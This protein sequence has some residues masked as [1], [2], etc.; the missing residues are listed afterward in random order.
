M[1]DFPAR[2]TA[3][4]GSHELHS[5]AEENVEIH[6]QAT[7]N[8]LTVWVQPARGH[9]GNCSMPGFWA[10]LR[11][12]STDSSRSTLKKAKQFWKKPTCWSAHQPERNYQ[13]PPTGGKCPKLGIYSQ[14]KWP[15]N[16]GATEGFQRVGGVGVIPFS[17]QTRLR[18]PSKKN[19]W[20]SHYLAQWVSPRYSIYIG[21]FACGLR[22]GQHAMTL[23]TLVFL[24]FDVFIYRKLWASTN[25]HF[26]RYITK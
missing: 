21:F 9:C 20:F 11:G 19:L 14:S 3:F 24:G 22:L 23:G 16:D 13:V 18:E 25:H 10:S 7:S 12:D 1:V 8:G 6:R 5:V 17:W 15:L 26:V 2:V 4:A